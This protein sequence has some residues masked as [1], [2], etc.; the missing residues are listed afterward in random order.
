MSSRIETII[1]LVGTENDSLYALDT[2]SGAILW[3]RSFLGTTNPVGD[4]NNTLN[5]TSIVAVPYADTSSGDINPTIGITGTPVIDPTTQVAYL[6][7]VTKETIGGA[8]HYVQRLHAINLADGTDKAAPSLIGDTTNGNTN[9]TPIYDYGT[10]K[11]VVQFNALRENQRTSLDLENGS[12]YIEWAS[13]GDNG[14]A[15]LNCNSLRGNDLKLLA[16]RS[17]DFKSL[18]GN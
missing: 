8:A 2:V 4:T 13:H 3:K 12:V 15:H 9:N 11:P 1:V 10:G 14:P 5:A 6:V 18:S 16:I 17:L 7:T